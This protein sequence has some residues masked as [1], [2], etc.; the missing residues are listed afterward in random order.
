MKYVMFGF[1]C[2][3]LFFTF[4]FASSYYKGQQSEKYGFMAQKNAELFVRPHSQTLGSDDAKVYLVEFMDP[5]C[6]TCAAFSPLVEQI[7]AANPG[8]IKLVLRYA[9]FHDGADYFVK[10]LEAAKKQGKY[11]ETLNVMYKSQPYWAS[12]SNPQPQRIWQFLPQAGLDIEQ[13]K[14]DMNDPAIAKLIAQ[15]IADA[16]TLNVR[17]TP[18]YFVNGKPL[19]TFGYRQLRYLVQSEIRIKYPQKN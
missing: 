5:A 8:K 7:M 18:G 15:D 4:V 12:H 11:W 3:V 19:Q 2:L 10:I 1:A 13:I 9:P 6:E 16:K 14:K 17:K